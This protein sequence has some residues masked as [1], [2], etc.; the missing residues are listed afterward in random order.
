MFLIFLSG[1]DKNTPTSGVDETITLKI[2]PLWREAAALRGIPV[3]WLVTEYAGFAA[4]KRLN[5]EKAR[6]NRKVKA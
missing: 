6:R 4:Y 3:E 2:R 1:L 5:R